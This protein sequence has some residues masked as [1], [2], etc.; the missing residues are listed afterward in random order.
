MN[1][2]AAPSPAW[3]AY[4]ETHFKD[5]NALSTKLI[6]GLVARICSQN[7]ALKSTLEKRSKGMSYFEV[8]CILK[9]DKIIEDLKRVAKG[10]PEVREL[11]PEFVQNQGAILGDG[12]MTMAS[13]PVVREEAVEPDED[14]DGRE[15]MVLRART[16]EQILVE[17]GTTKSRR[18]D[19]YRQLRD[20]AQ[21]G[22]Q[23]P[24]LV[25]H[26]D[27]DSE[28][29]LDVLVI[30]E[31]GKRLWVGSKSLATAAED[32][33][34]E[35]RDEMQCDSTDVLQ[36]SPSAAPNTDQLDEDSGENQIRDQMLVGPNIDQ[37]RHQKEP[38]LPA[39]K[40]G[41]DSTLDL[42]PS[43]KL[44]EKTKDTIDK[45]RW[46]TFDGAFR[47]SRVETRSDTQLGECRTKRA[48]ERARLSSNS[49]KTRTW[50]MLESGKNQ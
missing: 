34:L 32:G 16:F 22:E 45:G 2:L 1:D 47:H 23:E 42:P 19:R 28:L 11:I 26:Q 15:P 9:R 38:D 31:D 40:H 25:G 6:R 20:E 29:E 13:T 50:R 4:F 5:A 14:E 24:D 48:S 37:T 36:K 30:D 49:R 39:R 46:M 43:V 21:R 44:E 8:L 18:V 10:V 3:E 12:A 27:S 35:S 7:A 33:A 17:I 41:T